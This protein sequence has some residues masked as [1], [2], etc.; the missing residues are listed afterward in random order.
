M[1][2]SRRAEIR[3]RIEEAGGYDLV[4]KIAID[5]E[6]IDRLLLAERIDAMKECAEL[7]D[8][9]ADEIGEGRSLADSMGATKASAI[10]LARI[11]ELKGKVG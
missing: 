7:A 4:F 6:V 11:K 10:I 1:N 8:N 3:K 5:I 2:D 9:I